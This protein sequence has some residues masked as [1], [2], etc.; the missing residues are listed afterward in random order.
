MLSEAFSK[1]FLFFYVHQ[2]SDRFDY[3][4]ERQWAIYFNSQNK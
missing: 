2:Y 3:I 1:I 4:K